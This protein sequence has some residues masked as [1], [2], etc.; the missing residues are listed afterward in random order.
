MNENSFL[1]SLTR[2]FLD[3]LLDNKNNPEA[4]NTSSL[5][6]VCQSR[7]VWVVLYK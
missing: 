3:Q 2:S 7:L 6:H 5:Q 1:A 4:E